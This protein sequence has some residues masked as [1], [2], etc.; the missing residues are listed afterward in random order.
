MNSRALDL[1]CTS[2]NNYA[3]SCVCHCDRYYEQSACHTPPPFPSEQF[4]LLLDEIA[5]T[6]LLPLARPTESCAEQYHR[7]KSVHFVQQGL[8]R[9]T[10]TS[11]SCSRTSYTYVVPFMTWGGGICVNKTFTKNI[12]SRFRSQIFEQ[13]AV[14]TAF[15]AG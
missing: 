13:L 10:S 6:D 4:S 11:T 9:V 15:V 1:S 8:A 12:R 5:A 14:E 2:I 3:E 7:T